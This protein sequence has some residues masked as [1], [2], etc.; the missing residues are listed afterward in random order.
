MGALIGLAIVGTVVGGLVYYFKK[1]MAEGAVRKAKFLKTK[2]EYENLLKRL[3]E[4]PNDNQTRVQALDTGRKYGY[5]HP[6]LVHFVDNVPVDNGSN[7]TVIETKVQ[8][9]LQA[10]ML[11]G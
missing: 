11:K 4:N 6:N 3:A 7:S 8:S 2:S 1:A 5:L 9:D 10:R